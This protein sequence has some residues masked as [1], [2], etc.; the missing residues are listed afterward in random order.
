MGALT[1]LLVAGSG[2]GGALF[3][4]AVLVAAIGASVFFSGLMRR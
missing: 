4:G 2:N 3:W 1:A